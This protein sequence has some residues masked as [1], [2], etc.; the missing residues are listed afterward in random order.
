MKKILGLVAFV[1]A[2]VIGFTGC[3]GSNVSAQQTAQI[4]SG[5]PSWFYMPSKDGKLGGVGIAKQH[6][7][8]PSMQRM[9]AISRAFDEIAMQIGTKVSSSVSTQS[10]NSGTSMQTYSVQTANGKNIT[11]TVKEF[12]LNNKTG[13]LAVWLLKQ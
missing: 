6:V 8:G 7:R 13:E 1:S 11:A 10:N 2:L 9:L 4:K 3:S 12:W 5:Y